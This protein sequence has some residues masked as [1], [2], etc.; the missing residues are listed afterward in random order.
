MLTAATTDRILGKWGAESIDPNENF[1]ESNPIIS[2]RSEWLY[3]N[4]AIA[5][6]IVETIIGGMV[7][8]NG[9]TY[10]STWSEDDEPDTND[11]ERA[12]RRTI[13]R[14][15]ERAT[16]GTRFD[17]D[18]QLSR[19]DMSLMVAAHTII[20]GDCWSFRQWLP[21]RP[22]RQYQATCWRIV[23][24]SRIC[25]PHFG[26]NSDTMQDGIEYDKDGNRLG[27]HVLKHHPA[28][29]RR[30]DL[31]WT[32]VPFFGADG[33][34]A[35]T[36]LQ[37]TRHPGQRRAIGW[38]API[39]QLLRL[40]AG[41][42]EAKVVA[43]RLK[44]SMG[45]IVECDNPE[46]M[47][48]KD[49]NGAVLGASNTKIVPGKTYYVKKGT[50]WQTLN[51]Q[52]NGQDFADWSEVLL[53]MVC[54]SFS[55]PFE[56]V[57]KNLTRSNMASSRV[58]LMSAYQTFTGLQNWQIDH[59]EDPWNESIIIE[60]VARKRIIIPAASA[61]LVG[62]TSNAPV[63]DD[64]FDRLFM[65]RYGRPA[66]PRPD[67]VREAQGAILEHQ[68]LHRSL[69]SIHSE[70]GTTLEQEVRQEAQDDDLIAEQG[71]G[72]DTTSTNLS[73]PGGVPADQQ[74]NAPADQQKPQKNAPADQR[75]TSDA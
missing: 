46:E 67:P 33:H 8:S 31:R 16:T 26:A 4:D 25:N 56:M 13:D 71:V 5:H 37:M 66:R 70:M 69:S 44:A 58:A 51:F 59:V 49:R 1:Y 23:H 48:K 39:M 9:L 75:Q 28:A 74:N 22:G 65:A 2:S 36:H 47:A 41:T 54:A 18:G 43:D 24:S 30:Q 61:P 17:A 42:L 60:D 52:Y 15:I 57:L 62:D 53:R 3:D 50:K 73:A 72:H 19:R 32:F 27:V 11:A 40:H 10:H 64:A 6:A 21:N 12:L 38:F 20:T 45:L 29:R 68:G 35:L 14:S 7:G 63:N 55:I 34:P